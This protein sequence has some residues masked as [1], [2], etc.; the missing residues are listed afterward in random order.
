MK[1]S[2][3]LALTLLFTYVLTAQ[4]REWYEMLDDP[5]ANFYEIQQKANAYFD[6]VGTGHGMGWKAY[7]RWEYHA[8]LV[9][10][11]EGNFP[12]RTS[13][14]NGIK[15]HE[16]N[17]Q[18]ENYSSTS[19]NWVEL[20]PFDVPNNGTSQPTGLG[21]LCAIA[22]DPG[23]SST[24]YVGAASGG[25][26]KSTNSGSSW[27][28]ITNN[29]PTLGVSAIVVHPS[30]SNIIYLGTG[31]RDGGDAPGY[32]VYRSTDGGATWSAWNNGSTLAGRTVYE[33]LMHPGN[34]SI[35]IASSN[36]RIHRTADGGTTWTEEYNGAE[37]FKDLAFKPGDP[38]YVYAG[39]NSN[40]F[41]STDNG[42]SWT[43]ITSG[44]PTTASRFALAVSPDEPT[45]VYIF[46]GGVPSTGT[47][48]G[49]YRSTNSGTSFSQQSNTPNICGYSSTGSDGSSQ[50]SYDLALLADPT[51]ADVIYAGAINIWKSTN[52]GVSWTIVAHWTGSGGADDVHADQHAL[53]W[54][55]STS[56]IYAGCDGGIYQTTN[57]GSSWT[58]ISS[59]LAIAQAYKIGQSKITKDLCING[60]QDNGTGILKPAGWY[61]EIG[62]DGMECEVDP[63]DD[64]YM[65]GELYYG[66]IRRSS[67]GG[68]S[69]SGITG[70]IS[71][72]GGWVTPF[73]LDPNNPDRMFVGMEQVWRTDDV[74]A[75]S[76]SWTSISSF[77]GT[78][79]CVDLAVAP[80]N[81]DYVYVSR[82]GTSNFYRSTNATTGSPTW[83]DLESSLPATGVPRDIEISPTDPTKLWIALG[84][85]VYVSTNSGG[86]WT[87]YSTGL[88]ALS[89]Y[90][91][92]RD[93]YG[94]T[95]A[96]YTGLTTGVYYRDASMS[97]WAPFSNG[98]PLVE[99][100]ELNIYNDPNCA[101]NSRIR[102]GTYGRGL[103]ESEL[104]NPGNV[105]PVA[106]F[107]Q[108][109]STICAGVVV[110]FT[111][112]SCYGPTSWNW[113]FSGGG[114]VFVN[115]TSA[116]SQNPQVRFTGS[117]S[118]TVTLTASNANGS[119]FTSKLITIN[120]QPQPNLGADRG[121]CPGGNVVL[122][123]GAGFVAF[124]WSTGQTTASIT[125]TTAGTYSVTVFNLYGCSKADTVVITQYTN[126]VV[127]LGP[128]VSFCA[129]ASVN[130][131]AGAGFTTYLW[132]TSA[133]TSSI[134]VSSA[135]TYSVTVTNGAGCSGSDA[136]IVTQNALPNPNLGPDVAFC[137]GSNAVL[138]P[139]AGFAS[140][141][142]SAGATSGT[143]TVTTAGSYSVTV[144]NAF[145]CANSDNINV[146]VHSL[147][148]PSLGPDVGIC[149]GS[150]TA[151]S[152]GGAYSAYLWSTSA[153]TSTINVST[154]GTY[155]VTVT[156]GNG[157]QNSDNIV[158]TVNALPNVN[159]GPDV[160]FCTGDSAVLSTGGGFAGC[161][162]NTNEVTSAITVNAGGSYSV[163][164]TDGNG[165][166]GSDN[167]NVTEN[168]LPTVS[169]GSDTAFCVG[170]SIT[171]SAGAGF[172]SYAWNTGETT[173]EITP[174]S[175]G[176]YS[177]TVT[178]AN[179]CQN[180]DDITVTENALP[181]VDLGPDTSTCT[182]ETIV[183][184]AGAGFTAYA[185]STAETTADIT[186]GPG[187]YWLTVTDS[188]GCRNNDSIVV[189]SDP[190]PTV[191]L[192]S[193][194]TI[195]DNASLVLDA[196]AGM[197]SYFWSTA[198][199]TQTISVDG[200]TVGIGSHTFSVVVT[201]SNA[202]QN[203][204]QITVTV[205]LCGVIR[206]VSPGSLVVY[207]NPLS[208][209]LTVELTFD[210]AEV[211]VF[212]E[213]G[214]M[215]LRSTVSGCTIQL[216]LAHV[217]SGV[218][219]I[220][221]TGD[222]TVARAKVV[223]Q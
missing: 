44:V 69:F 101:T 179:G 16:I 35:M 218:Y 60:Y 74:K 121:F 205:E 213:T 169:L 150:S 172:T 207:P 153:T 17:I 204:S 147:P 163:T 149:A 116:T 154:A 128:D 39:S 58:D 26:W 176:S 9:I 132:N 142:W 6:S 190:L 107:D 50:A 135:G 41:R 83:T 11:V 15:Q 12:S 110:T 122:N 40:F 34:S 80:S 212:D 117:G 73:K 136:I 185:W 196:G 126:P 118:I 134:T 112:R 182:G 156:D 91:L 197:S 167:S 177:V 189:G 161:L 93:P 160:Q 88:P 53:E 191:N 151:L 71:E 170:E 140:Y 115:G 180:S 47:F 195:C 18:S 125:V 103:W 28:N 194:T 97:S 95:D 8:Q 75:G 13:L 162:W 109:A 90:T 208:T 168:A 31:D 130:I 108:S 143:L 131:N 133:T 164:V 216:D 65:Y 192:G 42:Q 219:I 3:T 211:N 113:T 215:I 72:S 43:E 184:S 10:D 181:A 94:P 61:T 220:E 62:G 111:D 210:A 46:A 175:A 89:V 98:L 29:L 223:K 57:G 183:I 106:C 63:W 146:T 144:T 32:G 92:V 79:T 23:N 201:D 152:P 157:C 49:L 85:S 166:Q 76:P 45:Y 124:Q 100:T 187:T 199:T 155:S 203:S 37:N 24:I 198:D 102:A 78:S 138:N 52:G 87:N 171:I 82:N 27:T 188:N 123:P 4:T 200:S 202:C 14:L 59:G 20:G 173:S 67:N 68:T 7:K 64:N 145:G 25:I 84:N 174:D 221:A 54:H 158:V 141:A 33:I 51:N 119:N 66:D 186:V 127:N 217:A 70:G 129:G 99:I 105:P 30:N 48:T 1:Q 209:M 214:V 222:E 86:S 81:S 206:E 38:T 139:G 19:G 22:F 56:T 96:L 165:C 55:P 159:L 178:D 5:N 114:P 77:S 193:D 104:C 2:F 137:S 21:R 148:N 120:P 36:G